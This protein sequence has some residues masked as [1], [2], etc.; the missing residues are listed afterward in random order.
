MDKS[1]IKYG[2]PVNGLKLGIGLEETKFNINDEINFSLLL[3]SV[4]DE[5]IYFASISIFKNF[6]IY[7][8]NENGLVDYKLEIKNMADNMRNSKFMRRISVLIEPYTTT[9]LIDFNFGD[10][11]KIKPGIFQMHVELIN[12]LFNGEKLK[13]GKIDFSISPE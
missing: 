10:L 13:S 5:K 12:G 6:K 7:L 11:Y 2:K 4:R 8:S 1:K 3:N 9:D